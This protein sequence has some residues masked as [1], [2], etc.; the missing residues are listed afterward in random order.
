MN[1]ELSLS[2][3]RWFYTRTARVNTAPIVAPDQT[4]MLIQLHVGNCSIVAVAHTPGMS[5]RTQSTSNII[6]SNKF[7]V[8]LQN[9]NYPLNKFV[10]V[11]ITSL[12]MKW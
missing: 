10:V 7:L 6:L 2:D 11:N 9:S 5:R 3:C 8:L 1:Y 12:L 4:I